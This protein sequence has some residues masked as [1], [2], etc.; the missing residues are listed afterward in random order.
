MGQKKNHHLADQLLTLIEESPKYKM[1]FGFDKGNTGSV[2]SR[3]HKIIDHY[4]SL[5]CVLFV[6]TPSSPWAHDDISKLGNVVKN[7]VSTFAPPF[8]QH[9]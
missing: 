8:V 3:G 1:V 9:L 5:A 2:N 7:C 6:E 4:H